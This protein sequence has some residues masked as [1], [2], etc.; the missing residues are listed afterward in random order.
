M[1]IKFGIGRALLTA[2]GLA[3]CL[4]GSAFALEVP[5]GE[6]IAQG[7]YADDIALGGMTAEEAQILTDLMEGVVTE[8]TA[9]RLS[10]QSYTAAGKTGTAEFS[11]DKSKSHA[12]FTGFSNVDSPDIVVTVIVEEAGSGSEYAVPIAKKIFDAYYN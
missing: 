1:R 3:C 11:S 5:E 8:G 2:V 4:S 7:V 9:S 6:E 10:G 12:W